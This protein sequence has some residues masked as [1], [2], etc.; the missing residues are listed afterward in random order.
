MRVE[1]G[2]WDSMLALGVCSRVGEVAVFAARHHQPDRAAAAPQHPAALSPP[3][4]L[5]LA[6]E[7][8][9]GQLESLLGK[10]HRAQIAAALGR[11][12]SARRSRWIAGRRRGRFRLRGCRGLGAQLLAQG[13]E[14]R[15]LRRELQLQLRRVDPLRFRH[16]HPAP[17]QLHVELKRAIGLAQPVTLGGQR[18]SALIR[19]SQRGFEL[20]DA[21][22]HGVVRR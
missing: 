2:M 5:D 1:V 17:Q 15:Q 13:V 12:F 10:I 3:D 22:Q 14:R 4:P 6:F 7:L 11:P 16:E 9:V 18:C 19:G 20:R 8:R 21:R